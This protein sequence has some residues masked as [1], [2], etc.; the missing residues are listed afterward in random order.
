MWGEMS[1]ALEY[2]RVRCEA[3]A[4][5]EQLVRGEEVTRPLLAT[6]PPDPALGSV[7]WRVWY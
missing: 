1:Q 5:L 4:A 2:L 7:L 3:V 6:Q